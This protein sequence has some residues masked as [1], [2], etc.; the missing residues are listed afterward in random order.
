MRPSDDQ[1][2]EQQVDNALAEHMQPGE[3]GNS[4]DRESF[5]SRYPDLRQQLSELLAVADWIELLSGSRRAAVAQAGTVDVSHDALAAA[6]ADDSQLTQLY[7]ADVPTGIVPESSTPQ[8]VSSGPLSLP[9]L[10]CMFGDYLLERVLGRGG[11]GVVYFGRQVQLDRPVAIKMIRSGTLASHVEVQRFYA[12]ARSAARLDHPNIVTVHQCGEI[13]G[14][15]YFSMDYV[16]GAD[17]SKLIESAPLDACRAARYVRDAARAIQYAHE[18]GIVH[19][20][21]KPNGFRCCIGHPRL[22]VSRTGRWAG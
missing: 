20:D 6:A 15:R 11:M 5:L 10:P 1:R 19:R 16:A 18:R 13:D 8:A 21:L 7:V 14:H 2:I 3:A 4:L 17:L 12:E 22:H 9:G